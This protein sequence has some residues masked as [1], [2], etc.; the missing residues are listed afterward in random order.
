MRGASPRRS[1]REQEVGDEATTETHVST[2]TGTG[3]PAWSRQLKEK[4]SNSMNVFRRSRFGI[5]AI[6]A[7]VLV[8]GCTGGGGDASASDGG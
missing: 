1:T 2:P 5:L 8:A 7:M 6:A 4:E 3:D